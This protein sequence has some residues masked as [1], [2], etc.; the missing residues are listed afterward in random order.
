MSDAL[1]IRP[2][3]VAGALSRRSYAV[4]G[5]VAFAVRDSLCPWNEGVHRMTVRSGQAEVRRDDGAAVDLELDVSDLGAAY[6]GGL[7]FVR[8]RDAGRVT[9]AS[10]GAL[11]RADDLFRTARAPW[12]PHIF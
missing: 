8:L 5:E 1:W 7:T 11:R 3:D 6:L 2:V 12:C 4:D 9:A 10:E